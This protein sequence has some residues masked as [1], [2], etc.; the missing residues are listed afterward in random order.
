MGNVRATTRKTFRQR[1]GEDTNQP[2]EHR[3]E[4]HSRSPTSPTARR[5]PQDRRWSLHN[6]RPANSRVTNSCHVSSRPRLGRRVWESFRH[7][8][9]QLKWH[10]F[11]E[12]H[13]HLQVPRM[14][15]VGPAVSRSRRAL[16]GSSRMERW[17]E[18][19][20]SEGRKPELAPW[21]CGAYVSCSDQW[22]S[23]S[24]LDASMA[25]Y[26]A[27]CNASTRRMLRTRLAQAITRRKS[28]SSTSRFQP[29]PTPDVEDSDYSDLLH[30]V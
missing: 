16:T 17:R 25:S 2:H 27:S 9:L 5:N 23:S 28:V 10:S 20:A 14:P 19:S 12:N 11:N 15:L 3:L 6:T 1:S 18:R 29:R 13:S 21:L 26:L 24:L 30:T 4:F 8:Q 22:C 7:W